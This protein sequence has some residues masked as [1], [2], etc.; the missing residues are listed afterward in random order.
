[1]ARRVFFSFHYQ[2]DIW[3]VNQIRNS[4]VVEGCAAAGF[5]DASLWEEAKRRGDQAVRALIDRGLVG[6]SITAVLIGA[7]TA[8]RRF[9]DYEIRKSVERGNGLLGIRIHM[10]PDRF[11]HAD[12]AGSIP[13]ALAS[14]G[15]PVYDWDRNYFGQWV[16]AVAPK[17]SSRL[18][19]Q[20]TW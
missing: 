19:F 14:A 11:G 17:P 5:Q 6:T 7:E 4:H 8:S 16:E 2:R 10:I 9:V 1:M 20:R 13:P 12:W 3:R 15:A 18:G